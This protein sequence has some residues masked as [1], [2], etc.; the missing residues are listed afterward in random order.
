M[1]V[2]IN[3]YSLK[4]KKQSTECN[5]TSWGIS[6]TKGNKPPMSNQG[7]GIFHGGNAQLR[8]V[9]RGSLEPH[10]GPLQYYKSLHAAAIICATLVN[11]HTHTETHRETAFDWLYTISSTSYWG[12]VSQYPS[13]AVIRSNLPYVL[14]ATK[15]YSTTKYCGVRDQINRHCICS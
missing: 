11:T 3:S 1:I 10:A 7:R 4:K 8:N 5:H 6:K 13:K 15:N 2:I 12:T 14:R 9:Q